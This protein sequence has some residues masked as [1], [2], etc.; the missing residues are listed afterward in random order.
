LGEI[1]KPHQ[2]RLALAFRGANGKV[3]AMRLP[4]FSFAFLACSL[5]TVIA[6]TTTSTVG[7]NPPDG[8]GSNGENPSSEGSSGTPGTT[9]PSTPK[10]PSPPA[11]TKGVVAVTIHAEQHLGSVN[12]ITNEQPGITSV[13]IVLRDQD[14]VEAMPTGAA[15][16]CQ[17][18]L[19][20]PGGVGPNAH[21]VDL[22]FSANAS[23]AGKSI[24]LEYDPKYR[25]LNGAF[26]PVLP[27]GTPITVTFG[28]EVPALAGKTVTLPAATTTLAN[29]VRTPTGGARELRGYAPGTD[30]QLDWS[31]I[32]GDKW[33]LAAD[34]NIQPQNLV[35]CFP[36][37]NATSFTVPASYM[38]TV[39]K[40]TDPEKQWPPVFVIS[41][42]EQVEQV[43]TIKVRKRSSAELFFQLNLKP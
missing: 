40:V 11:D 42:S 12:P 10:Q 27:D 1:D 41:R 19:N 6:C 15:G 30:L 31:Q 32:A 13:R 34:V 38:A 29:P 5:S 25:T 28:P 22:A 36:P 9:A 39:T 3:L 17:T 33:I 16:T 21:S 18:R 23:A 24:K 20:N 37:A 14:F 35:D 7:E 26:H 2:P 43:G 8:T 4:A